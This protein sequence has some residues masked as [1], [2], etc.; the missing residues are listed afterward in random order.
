[1]TVWHTFIFVVGE[2]E[3]WYSASPTILWT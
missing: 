1:M 2:L 3:P